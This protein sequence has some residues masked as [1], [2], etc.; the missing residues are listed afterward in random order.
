MKKRILGQFF[1]EK[2]N[3][4]RKHIKN[5]ILKSNC[6]IAYDPFAGNGDILQVVNKLTKLKTI[7]LDID[8][9]RKFKKNDSLINIPYIKNAIIITNPPYLSN[10]SAKRK[11]IYHKVAKYF[12]NSNYD[13]LYLIALE[14][15][16]LAQKYV[17]A[18][19]P[20]TF[21]NSSF[22]DKSKLQSI[23]I[24]EDNCF[25]DTENPVCVVCFDGIVKPFKKI[26]V[27]KNDD[28]LNTLGY[29]ENSRLKPNKNLKIIFNDTQGNIALR[30]VDTTN[31]KRMISF[32]KKKELDYNLNGIKI[33]S[34]LIT[35]VNVKNINGQLTNL[36]EMCNIILKQYR[37]KTNDV[38][39]S[40]FKGN[41]KNGRRRRRLD[42]ETARAIIEQ[43]YNKLNL[44]EK[45]WTTSLCLNTH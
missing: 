5:F 10:Y 34:R 13:D 8:S 1:T 33:S 22:K 28:Y 3:W 20:E 18:I 37:L 32:M 40:P 39:L 15:M 29:F 26:K 16:L 44:G 14:K 19:V 35:I 38:L 27:Y 7:G 45:I 31:P 23:T 41:M 42:Y 24:I 25:N 11:K 2:N 21:I 30:A 17:V 12:N 43:A 9:I 36:I 6:K 4:F